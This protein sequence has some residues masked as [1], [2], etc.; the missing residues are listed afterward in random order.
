MS[1]KALKSEGLRGLREPEFATLDEASNDFC[2]NSVDESDEDDVRMLDGNEVLARWEDKVAM[3][4][5]NG[6]S[7]Q[8]NNKR[9]ITE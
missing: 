1:Q 4:R 9:E 3:K 5:T 2:T 7:H 6:F 8:N